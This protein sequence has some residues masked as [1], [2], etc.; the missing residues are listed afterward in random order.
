MSAYTP[1]TGARPVAP[2]HIGDETPGHF[3]SD[4]G[5]ATAERWLARAAWAG[6]RS[7]KVLIFIGLSAT[8]WAALPA[9]CM[10]LAGGVPA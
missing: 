4:A 6:R 8:L 9:I 7:G 5:F 10:A 1:Y 2:A 3:Q